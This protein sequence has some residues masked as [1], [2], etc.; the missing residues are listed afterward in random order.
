MNGLE[1]YHELRGMAVKFTTL[2]PTI[3]NDG[4]PFDDALLR[5]LITQLWK[6]FKA[7]SEEHEVIGK[8]TDDDGTVYSDVSIKV[9][10]ECSRERLA[11]AMRAV[12]RIGRRL[13]QRAMYFEVSGYDG[14][15]ILRIDKTASE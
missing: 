8:W 3:G 12:K 13:E 10:I 14:V 11:E 7:M 9:S 15:Q 2:I 4:I 5:R 1:W 6:P